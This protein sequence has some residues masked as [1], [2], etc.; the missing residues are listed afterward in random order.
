MGPVCDSAILAQALTEPQPDVGTLLTAS[1]QASLAPHMLVEQAVWLVMRT[2]VCAARRAE[3]T[4]FLYVDLTAQEVL[5]MW[6]PPEAVGAKLTLSGQADL[7]GDAGSSVNALSRAL[8]AAYTTP[9]FF[10]TATQWSTCY[11][12]WAAVAVAT[13]MWT[14]PIALTYH[15]TVLRVMEESA[16]EGPHLGIVHD[17]L[18]RRNWARR[19][20]RS[21]AALDM[22]KESQ[23]ADTHVLED[24]RPRLHGML[25]EAGVT[26][27]SADAPPSAPPVDGMDASLAT[28]SAA[29][30]SAHEAL[31]KT[32][33][34]AA[35]E[36][37]GAAEYSQSRRN[38]APNLDAK[39]G[40]ARGKGGA[41]KDQG[42]GLSRRQVKSQKWFQSRSEKQGYYVQT[43]R[44]RVRD[45]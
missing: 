38:A 25:T 35:F 21:D 10:R 44:K 27:S 23:R 13:E 22:A 4:P 6:L 18:Q 34:E 11:W 42:Q 9:R 5:P 15:D 16:A 12:R 39:S 3:R 2:E 24:A 32:T 31:L 41:G 29:Q 14:W 43:A 28:Q 36:I 17:D 1:A 7:P 8:K 33:Q 20:A 40:K 19:A 45:W 30:K 26:P 37:M